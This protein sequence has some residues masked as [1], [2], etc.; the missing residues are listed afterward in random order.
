M[1]VRGRGFGGETRWRFMIGFALAALGLCAEVRPAQLRPTTRRRPML[2]WP[3]LRPL[4][5]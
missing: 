2:P 5:G 4:G 3:G 1:M